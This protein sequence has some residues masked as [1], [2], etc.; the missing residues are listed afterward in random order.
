[1]H[2]LFFTVSEPCL[3]VRGLQKRGVFAYVLMTCFVQSREES[4]SSPVP[5]T[6]CGGCRRVEITVKI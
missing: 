5:C 3:Q 1:M 4:Y 2:V 6:G